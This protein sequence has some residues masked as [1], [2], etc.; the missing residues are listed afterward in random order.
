MIVDVVRVDVADSGVVAG[1]QRLHAQ[2]S[3]SATAP[4]AD[5]IASIV[6]APTSVLFVARERDEARSIAGMLTL[7]M[8]R[9]PSGLRAW[10]EDVAVD[11]AARGQGIGEALSRAAV[12][13]ARAWGQDGRTHVPAGAGSCKQTLSK[14]WLRGQEHECLSSS[15]LMACKRLHTRL[16]S[17]Q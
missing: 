5:D 8:F 2:V 10:I 3:S 16:R 4:G 15:L 14:T 17:F 9:I 12:D 6:A 11:E 13:H 1:V 7:V